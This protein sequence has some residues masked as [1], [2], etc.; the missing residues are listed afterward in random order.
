MPIEHAE[1]AATAA[2]AVASTAAA[3]ATAAAAT[4]ST[5][6]LT[7]DLRFGEANRHLSKID[8]T[9]ADVSESLKLL[10]RID[11]R[12]E[13]HQRAD[14]IVHAVV[15][16]TVERVTTLEARQGPLLETRK[17]VI[18]LVALLFGTFVASVFNAGS[19]WIANREAA[20]AL[21]VAAKKVEDVLVTPQ[22]ERNAVIKQRDA[23]ETKPNEPRH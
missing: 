11:E 4:A 5:L 22:F 6:A 1:L 2:A 9:M 18:G 10:S 13:G 21:P 17:W 8:A 7:T 19:N 12:M 15:L 20:S 3:A 14:D 16:K 23:A